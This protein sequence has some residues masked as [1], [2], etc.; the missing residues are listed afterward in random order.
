MHSA[1]YSRTHSRN[2]SHGTSCSSSSY[3]Q[4]LEQQL[5][6]PINHEMPLRHM[7]AINCTRGAT[8]APLPPAPRTRSGSNTPSI[9]SPN[10][11]NAP[12]APWQETQVTTAQFTSN[13]TRQISQMPSQPSSLP[14]S[15]TTLFLRRVFGRDLVDVEFHQS[16]TALDYL[17]D[18]ETR[19]RKEIL[20]ALQRLDMD[21]G[22]AHGRTS[23]VT[24]QYPEVAKWLTHVTEM[25]DRLDALYAQL[26]IGFRRWVCSIPALS[27][28]NTNSA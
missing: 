20:A 9:G 12:T 4:M 10:S 22:S 2:T 21:A 5:S 1:N 15:F 28:I 6:N 26:Y 18:L 3:Q 11:P 25:E 24:A 16:L 7:Y 23:D 13:L 19:R 17:K 27:T 8:A 14:P